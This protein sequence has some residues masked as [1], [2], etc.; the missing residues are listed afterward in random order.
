MSTA[1]KPQRIL[2]LCRP[3]LGDTVLMGPVFRNLR[4]AR[5][6]AWIAAAGYA[7]HRDLLSLL[8]EAD[9]VIF[10]PR[11][12]QGG[13][14]ALLGEWRRAIRQLRAAR[15]D[16]VY[17]LMHSDRS[18]AVTLATGA[19]RRATFIKDR[20]RFRD[21]GYTDLADW[22]GALE[23]TH[24]VDLYLQ[25]L[26]EL[27]VPVRT[28]STAIDLAP[29]ERDAAAA[30]LERLAPRGD[31]PLVLVHPGASAPNKLWP[32]EHFA[33]ICDELQADVGARVL[34]LGGAREADML[35]RIRTAMRTPAV[36]L[37]APV[38]V[39]ELAALLQAADLFF[40]HD[41]GP[42]HLA[43]AVGTPVVALFGAISPV[44]WGPLGEAHV[45]I[46]PDMPCTAC[47]CP[48][49]CR[50]PDPYRMC[51]VRRVTVDEVRAALHA[52]IAA[53]EARA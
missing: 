38:S 9:E 31:G 30:R 24:T 33:V 48:E 22:R 34:L 51:C 39:R 37:D 25:G 45:V 3:F 2:V 36:M 8:P 20:R 10:I 41:S 28:R 43:A 50:P 32:A 16:L 5:P 15:F 18:A 47:V 49:R 21:R 7:E 27:G 12:A 6:D 17:D 53:W 46:R 40:G 14:L 11:R 23:R 1:P 42:M 4:A 52:Q 13:V 19:P 44:Q 26:A 29:E 35:A